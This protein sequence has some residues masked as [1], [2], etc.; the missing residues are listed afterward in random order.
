VGRFQENLNLVFWKQINERP[1]LV[2][3]K[4]LLV[5]RIVMNRSVFVFSTLL[6]S[7][8]GFVTLSLARVPMEQVQ[9]WDMEKLGR[10]PKYEWGKKAGQIRE[11][12]YEGEPF[13]GKPTR[14]FAYVGIPKGE[15]PFPGVVLVHGGGGR[16]F[17][18]WVEHWV[19]NG[20][21]AI[22]M[23][24]AGNGP[25]KK[26]LPDGGPDQSHKEKF[27]EFTK[28]TLKDV[29]TYHA[30]ADVILAH[31]LLRSLPEVDAERTALTGISWGG[32]LTCLTSGIDPRFKASVPVYGCGFLDDNSTWLNNFAAYDEE[33]RR[34]WVR[35]F[36]PGQYIGRATFP[37][38]FLNGTNDFAYPMDSHR[39]TIEQ[40][41]PKLPTVA[42]H[43]RLRH[44]HI[45]TF[46]EVDRY[47]DSVLQKG[48]PLIR[49]GAMRMTGGKTSAKLL[50]ATKP[51][52]ALL[53]YTLDRGNWKQRKWQSVEAT[54]ENG[55]VM[56]E[57]PESRPIAF[58]LEVTDHR[59]LKTSTTYE[60]LLVERANPHR[61]L[62]PTPKLEQDFYD[63]H[64]RHAAVL[65]LKK[66]V[67]P[68]VVLIGDSITHM[69]GGLPQ[70]PKRQNGKISWEKTFG[71]RALNLGFGWDRTQ[72]AIWRIDHGELD[73]IS[74]K[75]T[76]VHIGTNNLTGTR[77]HKTGSPEEIAQG[78]DAVLDR[79]KRKL[80]DTQ[81]VL[82]AVFP[83]G[84]KPDHP[85]RKLIGEINKKLPEVAEKYDAE[86]V[87]ISKNLLNP[88]GT[89]SR[90]MARDFLHPSEKGYEVWANA[91]LKKMSF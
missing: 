44:G 75:Y 29:W 17:E 8:F 90:E 81:L 82:M 15:G 89:F 28:C 59:G 50:N 54:L 25:G 86:F 66:E 14:V 9:L 64:Q 7:F 51:K 48:E 1:V 23:D 85:M 63:W 2:N 80:P 84:E 26:R 88:E 5:F 27:P 83:R 34:L 65:R 57:V 76:V 52:S 12:F 41:D 70:E 31:S 4:L 46:P 91:L 30:V 39:K 21:A 43:H 69:W 11:V 3:I 19:A 42:I 35:H 40:L 68:E 55:K 38:M 71:D 18:K 53:W 87:D 61:A 78:I 72:N 45:W 77:N 33:P 13:Q 49:L 73:G 67:N 6:W 24:T 10:V 62:L 22:A 56:A 58:Y 16:A 36:D 60:E 37:M 20:Y 47:I 79:V 74:P 32:Y